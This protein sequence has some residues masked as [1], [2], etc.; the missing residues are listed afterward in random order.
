MVLVSIG[1]KSSCIR[2][3]FVVQH[4]ER[5]EPGCNSLSHVKSL[6]DDLRDE[7][8]GVWCGR[9]RGARISLLPLQSSLGV[10]TKEVPTACTTRKISC[11]QTWRAPATGK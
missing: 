7:G 10:L 2:V 6:K 8:P 11:T 5:H 1:A 9:W 4:D 3:L